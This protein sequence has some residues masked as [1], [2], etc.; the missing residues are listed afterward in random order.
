[1]S[2]YSRTSPAQHEHVVHIY[3]YM[4]TSDSSHRTSSVPNSIRTNY[5]N[6]QKIH[7]HKFSSSVFKYPESFI[8]ISNFCTRIQPDRGCESVRSAQRARG[9]PCLFASPAIKCRPL[10]GVCTCLTKSTE[11]CEGRPGF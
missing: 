10:L 7:M 11:H 6:K 8:Q 2:G 9:M 5:I 3:I 4:Q 1:M